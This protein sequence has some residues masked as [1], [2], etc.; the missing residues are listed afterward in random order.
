MQ[1]P[2]TSPGQDVPLRPRRLQDFE[3]VETEP[4]EDDRE[5]VHQR[6][7]EVALRVLDHFGGLGNAYAFR[8]VRAGRNDPA[9]EPVDEIGGF[10]RRT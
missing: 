8:L 4:V 7:V 1:C 5:L 9:I 3:R 6:D 2:P 10:R